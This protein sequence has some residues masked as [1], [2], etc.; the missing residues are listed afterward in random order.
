MIA[1]GEPTVSNA[2]GTWVYNFSIQ[3]SS[4]GITLDDLRFAVERG[5]GS[6]ILPAPSWTPT[7]FGL[8]GQRVGAYDWQ[9]ETWAS[10]GWNVL[11]TSI[12]LAFGSGAVSLA[13]SGNVFLLIG[14][15][16]FQGEDSVPIP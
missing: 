1:I 16:P 3:E 12:S 10:G 6:Q 8:T 11:S 9:N 5:S 4:G 2:S 15:G 13:G 7:A 14:G